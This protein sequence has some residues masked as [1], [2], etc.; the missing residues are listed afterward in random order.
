LH[1]FYGFHNEKDQIFLK[2]EI[3]NPIYMRDF[4]EVLF[5]G[6]IQGYWFQAYEAHISYF[7]KLY[8]DCD[9]YGMDYLKIKKFRFRRNGIQ[10]IE[11]K[12]LNRHLLYPVEF[13]HHLENAPEARD[14]NYDFLKDDMDLRFFDWDT[15]LKIY[16]EEDIFCPYSKNSNW[17]LEID[18]DIDS[19]INKM[20]FKLHSKLEATPVQSQ[21]EET[22]D[23]ITPLNKQSKGFQSQ[24]ESSIN[25]SDLL[26]VDEVDLQA[27]IRITE[28][29]E[30]DKSMRKYYESTAKRLQDIQEEAMSMK[31][32]LEMGEVELSNLELSKI[33]DEDDVLTEELEDIISDQKEDS[34]NSEDR[35]VQEAILTTVKKEEEE[36]HSI[37]SSDLMS[38]TFTQSLNK[39]ATKKKSNLSKFLFTSRLKTG[40]KPRES[41]IT[42]ATK[43]WASFKTHI[44][45][46]KSMFNLWKDEYNRRKRLRISV[47]LPEIFT[48]PPENLIIPHSQTFIPQIYQTLLSNLSTHHPPLVSNFVST[49]TPD[50]LELAPIDL[51]EMSDRWGHNYF[52]RLI[53]RRVEWAHG[54]KRL[55]EEEAWDEEMDVL[56]VIP[57]MREQFRTM[58]FKEGKK[59]AQSRIVAKDNMK[60]TDFKRR[61]EEPQDKFDDESDISEELM[62][63]IDYELE[64]ESENVIAEGYLDQYQYR[65][66]H[67]SPKLSNVKA[68]LANKSVNL[69][70]KKAFFTNLNDLVHHYSYKIHKDPKTNIVETKFES[71][72]TAEYAQYL[73]YKRDGINL[74][75]DMQ[76]PSFA[77]K[78][79]S[80]KSWNLTKISTSDFPKF[81]T[82]SYPVLSPST[83]SVISSINR[84]KSI[85][86][87]LAQRMLK[88]RKRSQN[89]EFTSNFAS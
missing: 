19:I 43:A 63:F 15:L 47:P 7:M 64:E 73:A 28:G 57:T 31:S 13:W 23:F 40:R 33:F 55:N 18:F 78:R 58:Y 72:K 30:L 22:K 69:Y 68:I 41:C 80:K 56:D 20:E 5:S 84:E 29:G 17:N 14:I 2:I 44:K 11:P 27:S 32:P 71:L 49:V 37:W 85:K 54:G 36:K 26:S 12:K 59:Q 38:F 16:K 88:K 24:L 8:T 79:M 75:S 6:L 4:R 66:K 21:I 35:A 46:V 48:S 9:L 25:T 50:P 82:F 10:K 53:Y 76:L 61:E 77:L 67:L 42:G 51:E 89:D 81:L 83:K 70:P 74:R 86:S 39:T 45:Y 3:Y 87:E 62:K 1:S 52:K 34:E 60:I 65:Y